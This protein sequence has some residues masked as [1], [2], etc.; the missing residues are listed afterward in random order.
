MNPDVVYEGG[1]TCF[2]GG[3]IVTVKR[4]VDGD[5]LE[6]ADRRKV[7][8]LG[9]DAPEPNS[10]AGPGATEYARSKVEAQTV[11]LIKEPGV[12]TDADGMVLGYVQM[13]PP[14]YAYDLGQNM[15][16]HGWAKPHEGNQANPDYMRGVH[17]AAEVAKNLPEGIYGPPCGK[18]ETQPTYDPGPSSGSG[19]SVNVPNGHV[20]NLPDG[21]LTG[22]FCRKHWWC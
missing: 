8:L 1:D 11:K 15:V 22:G 12:G 7:R 17:N 18:P 20:P 21:A 13:T 19:G 6:L 4:V 3:E 10:C 16:L 2:K 9:I 14:Y 5:T